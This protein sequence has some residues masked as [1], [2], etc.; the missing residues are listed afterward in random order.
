[1]N[2][3]EQL[4]HKKNDLKK[5]LNNTDITIQVKTAGSG[6]LRT[7]FDF[8]VEDQKMGLYGSDQSSPDV[9]L[10]SWHRQ[11]DVRLDG[12]SVTNKKLIDL[13]TCFQLE[14][15]LNV[16]FQDLKKIKWPFK[17]GSVRLRISPNQELGLWLDLANI[18]IKNMLVE[19]NFLRELSRKYFIEIGQKKKALDINS[20]ELPQLKLTDPIAKKWFQ[21]KSTPL[22]SYV[23]SFTQPTWLTADLITDTLLEWIMPLKID[24]EVIEYGCGVGQFT[25]P[26][27]EK[28]FSLNVFENDQLAL[29]CLK[30][31]TDKYTKNLHINV[32]TDNKKIDFIII[33]PPRSGIKEFS[34]TIMLH[35]AKALVYISC[36]PESMIQ[37]LELLKTVY[38]LT[39]VAIIDQFPQTNHYEAMVLLQRID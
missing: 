29:E 10:D 8:T 30:V 17:K 26:L 1:M 3:S 33:N 25:V 34:K 4:E 27:L 23:S 32:P 21:T 28:N 36:Y 12:I 13:Q 9:K 11:P 22:L 19:K 16:A 5:K 6:Y 39:R 37:D 24:N 14:P 35:K 38:K 18:D 7:R 2:Y 15:K 31:N 20:F